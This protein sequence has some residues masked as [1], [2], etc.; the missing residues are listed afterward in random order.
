MPC[1]VTVGGFY[2][3]EGKG[4]IVA[5]LSIKDN[6]DLAAR[7]GAGPNAGHTFVQNGKEFKV[8]MLPSAVL[9]SG[10]RLLIGAGVL[11]DPVVLLKEIETFK[12]TDRTFIDFQCGIID[13]EHQEDDKNNQYLKKT[14]GTTGSGTGPANAERALRKLKLAKDV[15]EIA[16]YLE[17]V[18][19]SIN[20][21]IDNGEN[22]LIEGTQ[23][24]F[25]SLFHGT[26]P[27]VTSKDVT[28]SAICSDVGVGPKKIDEVL[29]VFKSY[30][31]RVG[32]GP[33]SFEMSEDEV[34]AKNWLEFGSVTGRQRR[35]A[36]FDFDL[37]RK[38]IQVNSASQI[39]L[40]KLD[41]VFP[42]CK[43]LKNFSDLPAEAKDFVNKIESETGLPVT[44]IGTGAEIMDT[45]DRRN[46]TK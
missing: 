12:S 5:Y 40:T 8:R 32:E 11:V 19:N 31:T 13:K 4:K 34:K 26:Y 29:V 46:S 2:G 45:I 36:P 23:G 18:S 25:L 28:A 37:A 16:L 27:Y 1:L 39:A 30:V 9:N 15:P 33:L 44:L 21:S 3:D 6:I 20:H 38:A 24:T 14:I 17:D 42:K 7:G 10:S 35:A 43:G 41:V 22:V